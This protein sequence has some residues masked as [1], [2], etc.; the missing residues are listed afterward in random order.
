MQIRMVNE[1]ND[2]YKEEYVYDMTLSKD[3][4]VIMY[5]EDLI[6]DSLSTK[7]KTCQ[8]I[9]AEFPTLREEIIQKAEKGQYI[10]IKDLALKNSI[11]IEGII[12]DIHGDEII[13]ET[14]VVNIEDI[15]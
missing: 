9:V 14:N 15:L 3:G 12:K 1:I 6:L 7:K 4:E 8:Y 11:T 5:N 10:K 2:N 13:I